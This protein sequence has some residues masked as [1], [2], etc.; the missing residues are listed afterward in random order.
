[1]G[2]LPTAL[3]VQV[4]E[5]SCDRCG[6]TNITRPVRPEMTPEEAEELQRKHGIDDPGEWMVVPTY[7]W[8]AACKTKH[9]A[10]DYS[11]TDYSEEAPD[12]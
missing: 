4:F 11:G 7:V 3:C 1:M 10:Q 8:C 6:H 2:E 12:A 9:Q 5:W